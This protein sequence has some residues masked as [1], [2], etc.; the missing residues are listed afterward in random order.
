M[1]MHIGMLLANV[2]ANFTGKSTALQLAL[3]QIPGRLCLPRKQAAGGI[4]HVSAIQVEANTL[5]Q[6]TDVRLT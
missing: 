3:Q 4:A 5:N 2:T 6:S 1:L